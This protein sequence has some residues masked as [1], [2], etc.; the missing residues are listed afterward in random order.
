MV[1][2]WLSLKLRSWACFPSQISTFYF[3]F[4]DFCE[5]K[6]QNRQQKSMSVLSLSDIKN[7]KSIADWEID[8]RPKSRPFSLL[9]T[10]FSAQE[11]VL[12]NSITN[13]MDY[14]SVYPSLP[15]FMPDDGLTSS[16]LIVARAADVIKAVRKLS[17]QCLDCIKMSTIE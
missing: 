11:W 5:I 8:T 15:D 9:I 14:L 2:D 6:M 12:A 16:Q 1:D 4:M 10:P 3:I 7:R 17:A 13:L